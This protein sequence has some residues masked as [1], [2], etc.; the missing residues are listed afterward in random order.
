V[1]YAATGEPCNVTHCHCLDCRR[2]GGAPF[3]TWASFRREAFRFTAGNPREI[4]WAGRVRS[5]CP[6][7]GT[8]LTFLSGPDAGEIDVTVCSFDE[9]DRV[10][11]ADHTWIEDCLPWIRLADQ[12]PAFRQERPAHPAGTESSTHSALAPS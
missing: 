7:C 1:R 4:A 6:D 2:A 5:F 11:P 12:L 3:V 8:P 10:S 9:P